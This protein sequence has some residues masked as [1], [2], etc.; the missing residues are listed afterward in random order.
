M[1]IALCKCR[2]NQLIFNQ[3]SPT[4]KRPSLSLSFV[5]AILML[6]LFPQATL[7]FRPPTPQCVGTVHNQF[8][9]SSE[10]YHSFRQKL[11]VSSSD[12]LSN[13]QSTQSR[14]PLITKFLMQKLINTNRM[15]FGLYSGIGLVVLPRFFL[16]GSGNFSTAVSVTTMTN[17][18][19]IVLLATIW[20]GFVLAISGMEAWLKFRAPFLPKPLALDVGRTIFPALN[21]VELAMC[22]SLW[23]NKARIKA[24]GTSFWL[25]IP[26]L[27]LLLDVAFL[28][29]QLVLRGKQIVLE[30]AI[31]NPKATKVPE[32]SAIVQ[33][34]VQELK[35]KH[36][37]RKDKW[38]VIYVILEGVKVLS[39]SMLIKRSTVM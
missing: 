21:S 16:T 9:M 34:L 3:L 28:T 14:R 2:E 37:A 1:L 30:Y 11:A 31:T 7:C 32:D 19:I 6:D 18:I 38:H 20:L 22:L 26:S 23:I 35:G 12:E 36:P 17:I 29:P 33:N 25:I 24:R 5:S 10:S 15:L 39:L 13:P 8:Y 4:M 27:V